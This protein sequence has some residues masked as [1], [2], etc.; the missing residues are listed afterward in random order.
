MHSFIQKP[1]KKTNDFLLCGSLVQWTT[2]TAMTTNETESTLHFWISS[3]KW[4]KQKDTKEKKINESVASPTILL[5]E[6]M[7]F[8]CVSF[9]V[10]S[11]LFGWCRLWILCFFVFLWSVFTLFFSTLFLWENVLWLLLYTESPHTVQ[12]RT[13][14]TTVK[15]TF[16]TLRKRHTEIVDNFFFPS[17]F[18]LST[19]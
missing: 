10:S 11:F 8:G 6:T 4:T 2:A 1:K 17:V 18:F 5:D 12:M 9:C 14:T 16:A 7:F 13:N 15:N 3:A 19:N